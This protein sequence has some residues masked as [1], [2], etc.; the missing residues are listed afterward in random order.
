MWYQKAADGGLAEAQLHM[1]FAY[2]FGYG[3]V[4]DRVMAASLYRKAA[5]QGLAEAQSKLAGSYHAGW[6]VNKDPK[7]E[8]YW[9]GKAAEQGDPVSQGGL[10][11]RYYFGDGTP[12]NYQQALIWFLKVANRGDVASYPLGEYSRSDAQFLLGTM[13]EKGHGVRKDL[14]EAHKWYNIAAAD[15]EL[16]IMEHSAKAR[17]AIEKLLTLEQVTEAQRRASEWMNAHRK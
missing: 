17:D 16:D 15:A 13:F 2:N 10:A 12:Q 3:V 5:E 14:V 11:R 6:G 4:Q 8:F 7:Q 9:L 1:G